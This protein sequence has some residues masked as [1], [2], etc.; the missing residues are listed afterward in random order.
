M[1]RPPPAYHHAK[2]LPA[3]RLAALHVPRLVAEIEALT[4]ADGLPASG[5]GYATAIPDLIAAAARSHGADW[6]AALLGHHGWT[7][8]EYARQHL[9]EVEQEAQRRRRQES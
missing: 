1:T 5:H 7:A 9:R 8:T 6:V 3:R 2:P 4:T